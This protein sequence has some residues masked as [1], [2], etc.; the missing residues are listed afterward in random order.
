MFKPD[1]DDDRTGLRSAFAC[2]GAGQAS[3]ETAPQMSLYPDFRLESDV[4]RPAQPLTTYWL[5]AEFNVDAK[6]STMNGEISPST[7]KFISA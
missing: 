4:R 3:G 1:Y 6:R 2:D 5:R 7:G